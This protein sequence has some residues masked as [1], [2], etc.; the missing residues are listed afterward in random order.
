MAS[1]ARPAKRH[2]SSGSRWL[3]LDDPLK[4]LA[5]VLCPPWEDD[6]EEV[7]TNPRIVPVAWEEATNA[8]AAWAH[9][10]AWTPRDGGAVAIHRLRPHATEVSLT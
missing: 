8:D 5:K 3:V 2:R 9:E 4:L 1:D 7:F 6:G 10:I